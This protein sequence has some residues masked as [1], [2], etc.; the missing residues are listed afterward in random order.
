MRLRI[1]API[2]NKF[3][4]VSRAFPHL[5]LAPNGWWASQ[6]AH[7]RVFD[8]REAAEV[9]LNAPMKRRLVI[10]DPRLLVVEV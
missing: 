7:A 2:L 6:I 9:F 3:V 5:Y 10:P 4:I 1:P 8:T